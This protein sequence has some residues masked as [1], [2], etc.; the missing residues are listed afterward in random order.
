M[1]YKRFRVRTPVRTFRD[2]EVYQESTKLAARIFNFKIPGKYKKELLEEIQNLRQMSKIVPKLI[3]ERY[4]DKF[5]DFNI[6][7][8]KLELAAQ[9]INLIIAKLDFLSAF[10]INFDLFEIREVFPFQ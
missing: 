4:N 3:V 8:R 2:L 5:N 7:D 9:T 10:V 1:G 6:A